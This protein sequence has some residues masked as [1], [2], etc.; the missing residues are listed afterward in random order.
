[1]R[2]RPR[3][4]I[5]VILTLVG[6]QDTTL[7]QHDVGTEQ[8]KI[9]VRIGKALLYLHDGPTAQRLHRTWE[10]LGREAK[11]LPREIS[12]SLVAPVPGMG[13]PAVLIHAADEPAM[14]G[15]LVQA[16]GNHSRL[17]VVVGRV[18]F[19]V[20]D[21]GAY[22]SAAAVLGC[23]ADLA[24]TTFP[25]RLS[26]PAARELAA[27]DAARLFVPPRATRRHTRPDAPA[28]VPVHKIRAA[29]RELRQA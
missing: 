27:R 25:R 13:E 16:A 6:T 19:D 5:G 1:M 21:L 4:S 18:M 24:A 28:P 29:G 7:A 8:A 15:M 12:P 17:R 10:R 3:Q 22:S 2:E 14:S 23:A 9:S 20:R 26:V 11:R